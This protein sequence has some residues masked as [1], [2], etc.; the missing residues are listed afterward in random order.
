MVIGSAVLLSI[1]LVW[2]FGFL[3]R[4]QKQPPFAISHLELP[5]KTGNTNAYSSS[6]APAKKRTLTLPSY[7]EFSSHELKAL[8]NATNLKGKQ[9]ISLLLSGL[10]IDEAASLKSDQIDLE[11]ATIT[12][13]GAVL[14]TLAIPRTLK[15]LF[16]QS[17]PYPVWEGIK[18]MSFDD[19]AKALFRAALDS[20][21]ENPEEITAE[22]IRHNY[23]VYLIRQG[24]PLSELAQIVGYLEPSSLSVYKDYAPPQQKPS[25]NAIDL[26]HPVLLELT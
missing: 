16:E 3:T 17:E 10:T 1:F 18:P 11:M 4:K 13:F 24:I 5:H 8:F 15:K 14:R 20:G 7:R 19:M 21:L 12:V 22:A 26:I 9:L 25:F 23:I 2:L 6:Q